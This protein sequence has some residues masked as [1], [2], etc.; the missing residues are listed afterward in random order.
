MLIEQNA[1][2]DVERNVGRVCHPSRISLERKDR[3]TRWGGS[4]IL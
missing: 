4:K 3:N 1:E 2:E